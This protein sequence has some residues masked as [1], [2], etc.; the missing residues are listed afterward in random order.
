MDKILEEMYD[1]MMALLTKLVMCVCVVSV[2]WNFLLT[3][4]GCPQNSKV[5]YYVT[6]L[7]SLMLGMLCF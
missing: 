3:C 5:R 7:H 4:E 6:L 2:F 1:I